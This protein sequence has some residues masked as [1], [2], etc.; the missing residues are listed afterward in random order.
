MAGHE[1]SPLLFA[2]VGTESYPFERLVRWV[3][4]WAARRPEVGCFVQF[5]GAGPPAHAEGA[6]YL[7]F[8]EVQELLGRAEVVVCHGGTGS[9]V[10]SR[11]Q[12]LRPI[13]VPR[14]RAHGEHVDDHQVRF[15]RRLAGLGQVDLA[16]SE[17]RLH[18]LLDEAFSGKRPTRVRPSDA[19]SE[20]VERFARIVETLAPDK[21]ASIP[22]LYVGGT[23]RSG[24]TLL[25]RMLG[26]IPGLVSAGEVVHLWRRGLAENQLC[27]CGERFLDC[28][29][30]S[31]VGRAGFGGWDGLQP[32]AVLRLQRRVD[33][34]RFIPLMLAPRG[35]Y[36]QDL[37]RYGELLGRLYAA[38]SSVAGARM[39]VDSS[40]HA[41]TAFLLRRVRGVDLR[42]VHLVRDSRGVAFSW[43]RHVR[44]P[45]VVS[46]DA[47]MPT[48]GPAR[49]GT[50]WV[51]Y[52]GLFELL[53]L[54]GVPVALVRYE[55]LVEDPRRELQRILRLSGE[56]ASDDALGFLRDGAAQ[57]GVSHTVSGNPMRFR[58]GSVEL[59]RD[60][61]WRTAMEPASRRL[62]SAITMPLLFRYGY[63]VREADPR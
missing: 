40:K 2:T 42:V 31:A 3:D 51:I 47:Y 38:L 9:I 15:A 19:P 29:Y 8:Q 52:N 17:Q 48:S 54:T 55:S 10:L 43:G 57:L 23:G 58:T 60:E 18:R 56:T 49:A 21:P 6:A 63:R 62:V 45:E 37:H 44:R 5:G 13:V 12:G 22:V 36:G 34:N 24:S 1:R 59:R 50:D 32:D 26:E 14:T 61:E 39:I 35:R 25:D 33:R 41:S 16:E 7:P 53:R 4:S 28:P 20:G 11:R 30:W 27:G 46:D